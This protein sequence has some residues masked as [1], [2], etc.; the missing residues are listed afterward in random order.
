MRLTNRLL[1]SL[2]VILAVIYLAYLGLD[3]ARGVPFGEAVPQALGDTRAYLASLA[4]GDLGMSEAGSLNLRPVAV[5]EILPLLAARSLGLLAVSLFFAVALGVPLGVWAATRGRY[6]DLPILLASIAG[7]S[8]PSFFTALLLQLAV[9]KATQTFGRTVL[10]VGGFGWDAHLLLPALVL[11]ARPVAQITRVTYTSVREVIKQDYIRT[12]YSKGLGERA[13]L[14]RH[15]LRNAAIPVLTT[16]GLSGRFALSSLPV[17][18]FFFGW[19]GMGFTLLKAIARADQNLT[20]ALVGALGVVFLLV[21][22][23]LEALYRLADPRLRR[24][25][26]LRREGGGLRKNVRAL[27]A[28][29][30]ALVRLL[31]PRGWPIL[32]KAEPLPP[33]PRAASALGGQASAPA[34]SARREA[35]RWLRAVLGNPPLLAGTLFMLFLGSLFFGGAQM[36]PHSPYATQGLTIV[37]GEMRVPPF[38]PDANHPWGTDVLG[39]DIQSLILA[40]AQQTLLLASLVTLAR[41]ALGTLLGLLAGWFHDSWL[42]RLL[43]GVVEVLAAFPTLLLGMVFILA[44]GIRE[45]V[46]PFLIALSLTGWGE[47]MQFARA[48]VVK[49]RPRPFIESA[50]AAGAATRRILWRHILPNLIPHLVSLSALE[51]GAVLMLL[52]ELG[53]VGIFIGG[54]SFAELDIGGAPYHYSDVPEWAALLSNVRAYARSYPWTGVYPALAFFAAILGFNLFGEGVRRL[55]EDMGVR[56]A[57]LFNKYTLA[58]GALLLTLFLG[59]QGS[60]G[61][62]AVY[63]RQARA[64]D[65]GAALASVQTL[66]DPAWEGR[67][68]GSGGM[69]AAAEWIA[70]R[71]ESLGL[72]PAGESGGYFQT[73]KRAFE[74][75]S[76][77]PELRVNGEALLYRRDFAE[78]AGEY[79]NL[80]RAAG[81]L[82]LVTFGALRRV[83]TWNASYP[84]LKGLDYSGE[85]LLLLSPWD[86][87]Y[88]QGVPHGGVLVVADSLAVMERRLTLSSADPTASLL[89]TGRAVGQDAPVLW[90]SPQTAENLLAQAG[91]TLEEARARRAAL[92]TDEFF[93]TSLEAQ[94]AVSVPGEILEG[95]AVRHVLGFWPGASNSQFAGLDDHLIVVLAQY[96]APPPAP[97]DAFLPGANDNA[98]GVA[99]MLE[100][101]RTMRESGYQPYRSILFVAYSGEGLEGG[102]AV[103]P[104]D[105]SKFLQAKVGFA[106]AFTVD[107]IIELRGLGSGDTLLLDVSGSQRLGQA[108]EQAARRMR[109]GVRRQEAP[110]DLSI[111]FEERAPQAGGDEAPQIGV[112]AFGWDALSHTPQDRPET[113]SA[114]TLQ[115]LGRAVTL[116]LMT[117]GR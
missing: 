19:P 76:A 95:V 40:G 114:E 116:A 89:G 77:P 43:L 101:V 106:S 44:L 16:I 35:R 86:V 29:G 71:F 90:I 34:S 100:L 92:G 51:M 9:I 72:Q 31:D 97:G 109:T 60:T 50:H 104:R 107:A 1:T 78:F 28:G 102:E 85:I 91:L 38:P 4:R 83:G 84:A 113:V 30:R 27:R 10:P 64:F 75:L 58:A 45:G 105:V 46:R 52:G 55:M 57:R 99:L 108:F 87:R 32:R 12:A 39:R 53:F 69:N 17:V 5:A 22:G 15:I 117:L 74:R 81:P 20:I 88:L 3:M 94:V 59:W 68:L 48:E 8:L 7:V 82:R 42:D 115:S 24:G 36:A 70:A 47:A 110:I 79:R 111:V 96:D 21:N 61:E 11:A 112:Y 13:I 41:L 54:G 65:G 98:S 14:L 73:R 2:L 49:L 23:F 18:E 26:T 25:N 63:A 80:G 67:A 37:N 103:K 62:T 6:A 66:S 33:M 56:V 93:E